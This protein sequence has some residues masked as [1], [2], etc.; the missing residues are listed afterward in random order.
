MTS[1]P[2]HSIHR[3]GLSR[4]EPSPSDAAAFA[5]A[6]AIALKA[7]RAAQD[8]EAVIAALLSALEHGFPHAR[9]VEFAPPSAVEPDLEEF[10][11]SKREALGA[12]AGLT[13]GLWGQRFRGALLVLFDRLASL[14]DTGEVLL[15]GL[16]A[17]AS[18]RLDR[19]DVDEHEHERTAGLAFAVSHDLRA[20]LR[21]ISSLI[22]WISE[23]V[24]E[25]EQPDAELQ[26]DLRMLRERCDRL[27]QLNADIVNFLRAFKRDDPVGANLEE[28]SLS[29][30]ARC[31]APFELEVQPGAPELA[32]RASSLEEILF[33]LYSNT[34]DH[35]TRPDAAA[36]ARLSWKDT[37]PETLTLSY[38]DEGPG[39]PE[40]FEERVFQVCARG[41]KGHSGVGLA[42]V[43]SLA[44]RHG[45]LAQIG[46]GSDERS[47]LCVELTLPRAAG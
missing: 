25:Q 27:D 10:L 3:L 8:S 24:Q 23:H 14:S 4:D 5:R 46:A 30:K 35:G 18:E 32:I 17:T 12:E 16:A 45:G 26:G 15:E 44:Q 13:L 29:A 37:G 38:Q 33:Q 39:L 28:A 42:V 11:A 1:P 20:P 40:G 22:S 2:E 31:A 19:I 9:S 7:L 36:R 21:Q 6:C 43:R 47:G 34:L 41:A